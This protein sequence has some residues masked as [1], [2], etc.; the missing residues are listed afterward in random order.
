M[1]DVIATFHRMA[2]IIKVMSILSG[3]QMKSHGP[4]IKKKT[5]LV[6]GVK[7]RIMMNGDQIQLDINNGLAHICC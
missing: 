5:L 1:G 2:L 6:S 3:I 4:K 7:Q